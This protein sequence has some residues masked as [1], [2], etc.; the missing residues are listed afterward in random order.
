MVRPVPK[1]LGAQGSFLEVPE[2]LMDYLESM[3]PKPRE[4][5]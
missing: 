1:P 5:V 2:G 4:S 3:T